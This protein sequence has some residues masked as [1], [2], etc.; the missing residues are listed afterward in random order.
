M[1]WFLVSN[2]KKNKR[3]ALKPASIKTWDPGHTARVLTLLGWVLVLAGLGG[4]WVWGGQ[5]L[6]QVVSNNQ[7]TDVTVYLSG[8]PPWMP[9]PVAEEL[10]TL[11]LASVKVDP[12]DH[13]SLEDVRRRLEASPWVLRVEHVMRMPGGVVDVAAEYRR[14][15]ALVWSRE[16][17]ILV[18]SDCVRLPFV[19]RHDETAHL[20]LPHIHGVKSAPPKSGQPWMGQDIRDGLSLAIALSDQPWNHLIKAIDVSNHNG[21]INSQRSH[22]KALTA[23][24][25][26]SDPFNNAGIEWGRLPGEGRFE[27]DAAWKLARIEQEYRKYP[28]LMDRVVSV[29][30]EP[31][32]S[33]STVPVADALAGV[34]EPAESQSLPA[35]R[36]GR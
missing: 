27:P 15:A 2:K 31:G 30:S 28:T 10:R 12:F 35:R 34:D 14:H 23:L 19:Y 8:L 33:Y 7:A 3:K 32:L 4:A 11:A 20:G 6:R 29:I 26:D 13:L 16:G 9:Q 25:S 21:R 1:G 5:K 17:Y 22:L 18:D 36:S 24:D